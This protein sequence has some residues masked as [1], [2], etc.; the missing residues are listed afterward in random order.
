MPEKGKIISMKL[1]DLLMNL[2]LVSSLTV[3]G[4]AVTFFATPTIEQRQTLAD[5][6]LCSLAFKIKGQ[7][8]GNQEVKEKGEQLEFQIRRAYKTIRA[9][10]TEVNTAMNRFVDLINTYPDEHIDKAYKA[11]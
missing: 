1:P 11:C 9:S 2:M 7:R 6:Y 3:V 5:A 4:Y 8:S 10:D